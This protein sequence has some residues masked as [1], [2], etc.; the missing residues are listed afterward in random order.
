MINSIKQPW[1]HEIL[2]ANTKEYYGRVLIVLEGNQTSKIFYKKNKNTIFV[3]Q[4]LVQISI[5]G[6]NKILNEGESYNIPPKSM[7]QISAIKGDATVL[8]AGN[9]FNDLP[10]EVKI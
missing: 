4:G 3:L 1:G 5:D 6:S 7:Y 9:N 8:E 10:V 2:W